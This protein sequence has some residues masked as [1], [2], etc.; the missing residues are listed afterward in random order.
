MGLPAYQGHQQVKLDEFIDRVQHLP[1]SPRLLVKL[2]AVFKQPDPN[3]DEV[4]NLISHDPAFTVEVLKRCNSAFFAGDKPAEDMFE[5]VSRLGFQEIYEIVLAM[6]AAAALLPP[7]TRNDSHVEILWR[8]SLA[9]A[10]VSRVLAQGAGESPA[11]AFTAGLLHDVGKVIMVSAQRDDYAQAVLNAG[12]FHR[13]VVVT[14]KELFGFDH[15]EVG[16]RLLARWNLPANIVAA[17][18]HHH[19][20]EGAGEHARLAAIIQLAN[21]IAH[22][23]AE[24]LTGEPRGL[25]AATPSLLALQLTPEGVTVLLPPMREGLERAKNLMPV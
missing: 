21:L 13:P 9:V 20:L 8:H 19:H 6:F 23:T 1:P 25:Q 22:G 12:M 3:I 17:V 18:G 24:K 15:A 4:V 2:L 11:A 16:A 5:A 14:E 10:V 7:G